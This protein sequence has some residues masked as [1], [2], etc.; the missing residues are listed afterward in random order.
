LSTLIAILG[1]APGFS[2]EAP[3][4]RK[5]MDMIVTTITAKA[6][7]LALIFIPPLLDDKEPILVKKTIGRLSLCVKRKM[8]A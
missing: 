7:F 1:A 5:S 2:D 6:L 8:P 4:A 3:K